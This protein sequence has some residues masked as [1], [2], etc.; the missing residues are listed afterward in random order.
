MKKRFVTI[1]VALVCAIACT[2]GLA[3]CR[4]DQD[5][6]YNKTYTLTGT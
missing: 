1:V 3:G 6:F 4:D 5:P 2:V